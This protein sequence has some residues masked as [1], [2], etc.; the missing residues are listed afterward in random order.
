MGVQERDLMIKLIRERIET[1][2][3][4]KKRPSAKPIKKLNIVPSN[5]PK[6][7]QQNLKIMP[8]THGA[9]SVNDKI[10]QLVEQ[11]HKII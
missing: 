4:T 8:S 10:K 11:K 1:S 6:V 9:W 2:T 5:R 7:I 3:L